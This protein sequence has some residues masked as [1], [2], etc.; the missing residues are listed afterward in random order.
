M[1]RILIWTQYCYVSTGLGPKD[2]S[3]NNTDLILR[4]KTDVTLAPTCY[5]ARWRLV[6]LRELDYP[7][8]Y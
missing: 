2:P 1:V 4:L 7:E 6:I 3:I 5:F 8:E